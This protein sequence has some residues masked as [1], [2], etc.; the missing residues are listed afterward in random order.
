M[1]NHSKK[2]LSHFCACF[3]VF[4]P[5]E[6][7]GLG[8]G[9]S[10]PKLRIQCVRFFG[11]LPLARNHQ[12]LCTMDIY[13]GGGGGFPHPLTHHHRGVRGG[14]RERERS[15]RVSQENRGKEWGDR[16]GPLQAGHTHQHR[17]EVGPSSNGRHSHGQGLSSSGLSPVA[18]PRTDGQIPGGLFH[19][20]SINHSSHR[21]PKQGKY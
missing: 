9:A 10:Q 4:L 15:A 2:Q 8:G 20:R 18:T 3:W 14:R 1:P 17:R 7:A 19:G 6:K 5:E 11:A 21:K 13:L 16:S 12:C